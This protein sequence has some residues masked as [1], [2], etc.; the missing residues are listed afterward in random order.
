MSKILITGYKDKER[1]KIEAMLTHAGY[2]VVV[3]VNGRKAWQYLQCNPGAVDLVLLDPQLQDIPAESLIEQIKGDKTFTHLPILLY[4]SAPQK[5]EQIVQFM[6]QGAF[7]Y[8]IAPTDQTV[9]SRLIDIALQEK[10]RSIHMIQEMRKNQRSMG[11]MDY[12][13][14]HYHTVKEA[15]NL[16]YLLASAFPKP[17]EVIIG[18]ADLLINAVEHGNLEID[19]QTKSQLLQQ[20]KLEQEIE[21]RLHHR[22]Y[23]TRNVWVTYERTPER[24]SITIEDE[25]KGF[26]WQSYN[27]INPERAATSDGR[28]VSVA[29]FLCFDTLE[30][31]GT[32]NRVTAQVFLS[33]HPGYKSAVGD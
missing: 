24:I 2:Q 30:Y 8:L 18:L 5:K 7:H 20:G 13:R 12:C 14:F 28:A 33:K 9:F 1:P 26:D 11:C 17:E 10:K 21:M 27:S 3:A 4:G 23:E 25:G 6:M 32:G 31:M 15:R 19:F 22:E 29:R 16:A